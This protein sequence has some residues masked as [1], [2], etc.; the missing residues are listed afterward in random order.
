MKARCLADDD[1]FI[2]KLRVQVAGKL[3]ECHTYSRN[4][5]CLDNRKKRPAVKEGIQLAESFPQ[6]H[7]LAA[8]MRVH[9][10]QLA[11]A[12]RRSK[13]DETR[14]KPYHNKPACT[15][16]RLR[17]TCAHNKDTGTDHG[18]DNKQRGI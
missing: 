7:I 8:C 14:N 4:G 11:I 18:A 13:G 1:I 16:Y 2:A 9:T 3:T 15:A 12:E 5:A 10:A 6:V 17:D